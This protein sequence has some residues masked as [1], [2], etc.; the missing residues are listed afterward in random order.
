[1][2]KLFT[3]ALFVCYHAVP[4]TITDADSASDVTVIEGESVEL[5]CAAT[6]IPE[7]SITWY[8]RHDDIEQKCRVGNSRSSS[9]GELVFGR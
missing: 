2:R 1:M 5:Q 3:Y 9:T 4:P 7:P 8:K 6:G